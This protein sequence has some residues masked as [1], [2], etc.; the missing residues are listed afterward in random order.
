MIKRFSEP[1]M[2][3]LSMEI[4]RWH[5]LQF[6]LSQYGF[7][8]PSL[9]AQFGIC[10]GLI[11]GLVWGRRPIATRISLRSF[12]CVFGDALGSIWYLFG[13]NPG[14]RTFDQYSNFSMTFSRV[15]P[16]TKTAPIKCAVRYVEYSLV[17]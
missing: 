14:S 17:M 13:I 1:R 2:A 9:R 4:G 6:C 7:L 8:L 5:K 16:L 15:T 3:S 11:I 10:F 12:F